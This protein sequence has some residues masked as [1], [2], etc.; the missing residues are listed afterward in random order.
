MRLF[1]SA[2]LARLYGAAL[3][4][5]LGAGGV[6]LTFGPVLKPAFYFFTGMTTPLL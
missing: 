4:L 2:T 3:F 1:A 5:C 6:D